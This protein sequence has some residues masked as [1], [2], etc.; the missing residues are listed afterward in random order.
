MKPLILALATALPQFSSDQEI[1]AKKMINMFQL[2]DKAAQF[3]ET[4]SAK[5]QIKRRYSVVEEIEENP[6]HNEIFN[7]NFLKNMP[8]TKLRNEIYIKEAPKLAKQAA[9][10]ALKQWNRDPKE[11]THIIS[12]SCTGV[13]APGIEFILQ[14]DLNLSENV[15]RL[16]INFMGC[17]GAFKGLEVASYIAKENQNNR[18]LVVCTEL[19]SLHL[20]FSTNPEISIGNILFGDGAAAVIIG[21]EQ[22]EN[23]NPLWS[24]EKSG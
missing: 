1:L 11:I 12:I 19:C 20:Q 18:I 24:I 14:Q 8:G 15:K 9:E 5:S 6:Q 17:F 23:E 4:I 7:E 16:G 13:M 2:K 22:R 3:V 10:K 21:A